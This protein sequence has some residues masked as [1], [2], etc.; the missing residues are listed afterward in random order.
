[1]DLYL[2]AAG[3]YEDVSDVAGEVASWRGL[4]ACYTEMEANDLAVEAKT[5]ADNLEYELSQTVDRVSNTLENLH[6]R[7]IGVSVKLSVERQ[8]ER[9][10]AIVPRL[11]LERRKCKI[12]IIEEEKVLNALEIMLQDKNAVRVQAEK[13]LRQSEA[14][15]SSFV[16]SAVFLGVTTRYTIEEF[17]TNVEAY[18]KQ[19]D[20]VK[21]A[22]EVE[23]KNSTIR[24]SNHNDRIQ[25]VSQHQW[26]LFSRVLV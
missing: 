12:A 7:L 25:E 2:K 16:D 9:V 15:D 17:K 18:I 23:T 19:L 22:I 11:R 20:V 4:A 14:S 26:L 3:T 1:M 8:C 6:S 21:A 13:D 24:I 10:G 5:K